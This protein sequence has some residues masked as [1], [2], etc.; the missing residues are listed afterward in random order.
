M[1]DDETEITAEAFAQLAEAAGLT[2][3]DAEKVRMREGY[4]GLQTLLARL[5]DDPDMTDEPAAVFLGPSSRVV[6]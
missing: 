2:L 1:S 6:R 3:D 4:I 5:P